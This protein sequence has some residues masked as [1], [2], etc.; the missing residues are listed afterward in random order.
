[1]L[2]VGLNPATGVRRMRQL[3]ECCRCGLAVSRCN[4]LVTGSPGDDRYDDLLDRSVRLSRIRQ[5]TMP[6]VAAV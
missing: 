6:S 4:V 3:S 1:M 2:S 5:A